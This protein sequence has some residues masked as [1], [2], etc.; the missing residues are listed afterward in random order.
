MN[1][2]NWLAQQEN[3]ISIRPRDQADRRITVTAN[4]MAWLFWMSIVFIPAI[5]FFSGFM[6]WLRRR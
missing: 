4:E 6:S 3:L 2:V 1:T 5:V